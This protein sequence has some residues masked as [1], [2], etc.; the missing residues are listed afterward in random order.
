V[1]NIVN[2]L[3]SAP[4]YG[5]TSGALTV[6]GGVGINGNLNIGNGN[7]HLSYGGMNINGDSYLLGNVT[8]GVGSNVNLQGN[9]NMGDISLVTITGGSLGYVVT[10]DGY[11]NLSWTAVAQLQNQFNGGTIG[12]ILTV[13]NATISTGNQ[14]GALVVTGGAYFGQSIYAQGGININTVN[15]QMVGPYVDIST[16]PT[17]TWFGDQDTGMFHPG[18]GNIAFSSNGVETVRVSSSGWVGV[19]TSNPHTNLHVAGSTYVSGAITSQSLSTQ[20]LTANSLQLTGTSP[21]TT[22]MF[23]PS[24]NNLGFAT[25][26]VGRMQIDANGNVGI[27]NTAPFNNLVVQR[28]NG[29]NISGEAYI[30]DGLHWMGFN[31][32]STAALNSMVYPG[33]ATIIYSNGAV[34]GGNLVIASRNALASG[35]KIDGRGAGNVLINYA[36]SSGNYRLQV[37]GQILA[38]TNIIAVSDRRYKENI[39]PVGSTLDLINRFN[40]VTYDWSDHEV[41]DFPEGPMVGF[42]AQDMQQ[43]LSGTQYL[44]SVVHESQVSMPDGSTEPYIGI[45]ESSLIPLLTKAIQE[46]DAKLRQLRDEFDGYK[47]SHP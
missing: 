9:V 11:G 42:V 44:N 4:S 5:I 24:T 41:H 40:P 29:Q 25:A 43:A 8:T 30:T 33:D 6:N 12:N 37:N 22:G 18:T 15:Q 45:R 39:T 38:T 17:Y 27:G 47:A 19:G 20:T 14:D 35:I 1:D 34:S 3:N 10:T 36:N 28:A 16:T 23:Q 32:N 13:S 31:S 2:I 21:P 7:L 26:G 46:L